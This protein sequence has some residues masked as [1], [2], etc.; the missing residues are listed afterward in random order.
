MVCI[1]NS[2]AEEMVECNYVLLCKDKKHHDSVDVWVAQSAI[3]YAIQNTTG[4]YHYCIVRMKLDP[5]NLQFHI[6][7]THIDVRSHVR[8]R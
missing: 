8:Q 7:A 6:V 4:K 5:L 2:H 3:M 1:R